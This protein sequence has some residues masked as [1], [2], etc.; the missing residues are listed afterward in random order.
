MYAIR[1]YYALLLSNNVTAPLRKLMLSAQTIEK[2]GTLET[3]I[4]VSGTMETKELGMILGQMIQSIKKT[5]GQLQQA[6]KMETVGT[7]A[8][9]LAHDFN[10]MLGGIVGTLSLIE[11]K[12][13]SYN[14]V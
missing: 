14:F 1:S 4:P 8:G 2:G 10:N 12:L 7:L 13:E 6:Q 5:G 11:N 3:D 9:G